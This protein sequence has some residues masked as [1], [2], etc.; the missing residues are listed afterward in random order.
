MQKAYIYIGSNNTSHELELEK[1]QAII[2]EYFE[3]FTA[4]EVVGYWK[5]SK[6]KTLKVEVMLADGDAVKATRLCKDLAK[7]LSQEAILL[8]IINSNFAFIQ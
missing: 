6:E 8:E 2:S 7:Q 3:G 4:Y 1:A 5:G